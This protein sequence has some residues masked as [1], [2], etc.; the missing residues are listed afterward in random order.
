MATIDMNRVHSF[1]AS[2]PSR[3]PDP[4]S[5]FTP[6]ADLTR[7]VLWPLVARRNLKRLLTCVGRLAAHAEPDTRRVLFTLAEHVLGW[8]DRE[9]EHF[10]TQPEVTSWIAGVELGGVDDAEALTPWLGTFVLAE[11]M[12]NGGDLP[13]VPVAL[14]APGVLE[15]RAWG[16]LVTTEPAT[17]P[18]VLSGAF[19]G[20]LMIGSGASRCEVVA[21]ADDPTL[22][23]LPKVADDLVVSGLPN[24]WLE[25]AL[26][27]SDQVAALSRDELTAFA[28][29]VRAGADLLAR[30][31]PEAWDE[32][33]AILRWVVPL[34]PDDSFYVPGFRGL[35][36]LG[37]RSAYPM[38][39]LIFH[40]TSHNRF[41]T[42]LELADASTNPE[43][44]IYS[45]FAK[46]K[47]P[48]TD[49]LH[50][51]WSFTREFGLLRRLAVAD[52]LPDTDQYRK[53]MRKFEI[54]LE[55]AIPSLHRNARLTE[56][57]SAVLASIEEAA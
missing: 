5:L 54:F 32:V 21:D 51:C 38:P 9:L 13:S 2:G 30:V 53:L 24:T 1:V 49:L 12:R 39:C 55:Q 56:L 16:H 26:P 19:A 15:L 33:A 14:S 22:W 43:E 36:A 29:R 57:G 20:V 48:V 41:S 35:I 17:A 44:F 4:A 23:A 7:D 31:W 3:V 25:R 46:G 40:E 45:P 42:I 10:L 18:V 37:T 50:S 6:D 27:Q 8:A 28:S 52:E 11:T 34:T 47:G